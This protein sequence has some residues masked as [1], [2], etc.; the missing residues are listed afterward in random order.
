MCEKL[1]IVSWWTGTR[2]R[3]QRSEGDQVLPA[4]PDLVEVA[5]DLAA[6]KVVIGR[7]KAT[8]PEARVIVIEI[9][10]AIRHAL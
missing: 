5:V 6:P 1:I 10:T 8:F 2:S 7:L 9:Q 4:I 3:R